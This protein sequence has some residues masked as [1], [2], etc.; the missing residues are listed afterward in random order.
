MFFVRLVFVWTLILSAAAPAVAEGE[1]AAGEA[2]SKPCRTCHGKDGIGTMPHFPNLA[3]QKSQ[4]LEQQLLAYRAG[5]RQSEIMNVIA[6]L[7]SDGDIAD[8]A[9][10][11]ASL[12]PRGASAP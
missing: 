3:G 9:A 2:K 11:F 10:H 8:L 6:K 7:L 5:T 1:A 12:D 4:Y